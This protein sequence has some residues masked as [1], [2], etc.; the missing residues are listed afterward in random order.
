[1]G[2]IAYQTQHYR[3][4]AD[5]FRKGIAADPDAYEPLVNLGGVLL[6]LGNLDEACQY[7]NEAVRQRPNDALAQSQLGLT[8]LLLNQLELSEQHL[9]RACQL[10]PG[11]FSHPQLH[12]AEVYARRKEFR[13]AAD[14]LDAFLRYH[15]DW[16][17]AAEV[18]VT[19]ERWRQ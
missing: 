16:P 9:L 12:L 14:Q 15:P 6:N 11:H 3:E 8:Y 17:T 18:K 13:R 1:L 4:A 7:N 10:D 19:I 2:T 5:Y